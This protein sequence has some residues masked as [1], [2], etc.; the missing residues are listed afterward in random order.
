MGEQKE[1]RKGF[2]MRKRRSRQFLLALL[3]L[4][5]SLSV[6]AEPSVEYE[7]RYQQLLND[8]TVDKAQALRELNALPDRSREE[9]RAI[10]GNL[11]RHVN[12]DIAPLFEAH[13]KRVEE[14]IQD[15]KLPAED[16]N[17][18]VYWRTLKSPISSEALEELVE[19]FIN[20]INLAIQPDQSQLIEEIKTRLE[21][22]LDK[23][24]TAAKERIE[25]PFREILHRNLPEFP[26][27]F[28]FDPPD[29]GS[30]GIPTP[31]GPFTGLGVA[32]VILIIIGR[33]LRRVML[34]TTAR[35]LGKVLTK[36]IPILGWVLVLI[37]IA[38]IGT[39]KE[40]ME[41][42]MRDLFIT[43][44]TQAFNANTLWSGSRELEEPGARSEVQRQT[45]QVLQMT[46][47]SI[48]EQT[49]RMISSMEIFRVAPGAE[50]FA[51]REIE[52][53]RSNTQILDTLAHVNSVFGRHSG[54]LPVDE[55][56]GIISRSGDEG[57]LRDL[58]EETGN[59]FFDLYEAHGDR[60]V[61]LRRL[62][63]RE[64][65]KHITSEGKLDVALAN[66]S[67]FE[68]YQVQD[69]RQGT[70]LWKLIER[71]IPLDGVNIDILQRIGQNPHQFD[72]VMD[73][74]DPTPGVL[75]RIYSS[76]Q[77]LRSASDASAAY[78]DLAK[79][80]YEYLP[81]SAW[82]MYRD[83]WKDLQTLATYRRQEQRQSLGAF[84]EELAADT[85]MLR[86]YGEHGLDGMRIWDVHVDSTSGKLQR[87]NANEALGYFAKGYPLERLK[88]VADLKTIKTFDMIPIVGPWA[89]GI[90][91]RFGDQLLFMILA[92]VAALFLIPLILAK[93][94]A[95]AK[96]V[97][98]APFRRGTKKK[99]ERKPA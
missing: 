60:I 64:T 10:L 72:M 51:R 69:A 71:G 17:L 82:N 50:E 25:K 26:S 88:S 11:E 61:T 32:G 46:T 66:I 16:S 36:A 22:E 3:L 24:V 84:F 63:G 98:R 30:L 97:F 49:H 35:V 37:D 53:G 12:N 87:D 89:Y 73:I 76:E 14:I 27:Y 23:E 6:H 77:T 8:I 54:V 9:T 4:G 15:I 68:Q 18:D 79:A 13:H 28:S 48:R 38:M 57:V 58:V 29:L 39:T 92:V 44:Y 56:L 91:Y 62:L 34:R 43:E 74:L 78:P 31:T 1:P 21:P 2:H 86:V 7:A 40:R 5:L 19:D 96:G 94:L 45:E 65:F 70:G 81:P 80:F 47:A 93:I 33:I 85:S 59:S 75:F 67:V 95:W 20:R 83:N 41:I 55:M 99:S 90:Y 52:R 42:E